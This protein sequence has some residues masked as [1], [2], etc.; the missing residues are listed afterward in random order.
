MAHMVNH[1]TQHRSE[2][3]MLLTELGHSPGNL[4]LIIFV[5]ERQ[6]E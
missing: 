5:S 1:G 4:D 2:L 6:G 3:A